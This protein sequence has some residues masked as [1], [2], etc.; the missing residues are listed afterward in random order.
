VRAG[1][2][3]GQVGNTGNARDTSPHLHYGVTSRN[4]TKVNPYPWLRAT[5]A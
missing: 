2:V 1:T 4:G 3:I 5:G